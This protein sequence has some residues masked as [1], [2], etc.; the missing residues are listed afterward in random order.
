MS[1]PRSPW[2]ALAFVGVGFT[3]LIEVGLF[4]LLGWW[5]DGRLRSGP[6]GLAVSTMVGLAAATVWL[7]RSVERWEARRRD[8]EKDSGA[9]S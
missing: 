5:V 2:D 4:A 8:R 6:I 1:A 7:L 3:F 9:S